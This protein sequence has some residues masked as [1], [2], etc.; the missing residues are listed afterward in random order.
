[1]HTK[2]IRIN[3][4]IIGYWVLFIL[5]HAKEMLQILKRESKI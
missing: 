5:F 3:L 2:H 4:G 1:M